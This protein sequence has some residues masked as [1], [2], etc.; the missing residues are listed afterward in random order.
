MGPRRHV[1][2]CRIKC[3][4]LQLKARLHSAAPMHLSDQ[5]K[6][7]PSAA[8]LARKLRP[9][10]RKWTNRKPPPSE[11]SLARRL[12]DRCFILGLHPYRFLHVWVGGP[13]QA[14]VKLEC[15][16]QAC[17]QPSMKLENSQVK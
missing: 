13:L 8:V 9:E 3:S 5:H 6:F 17:P 12:N 11:V 16:L 10:Y 2:G 4:C 14:S 1:G 7:P 15:K